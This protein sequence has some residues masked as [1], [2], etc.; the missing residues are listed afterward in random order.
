MKAQVEIMG[1]VIVVILLVVGA[2]LYLKFG[3]LQG[4]NIEESNTLQ[5]NYASN[6]LNSI[7]NVR[8]CDKKTGFDEGMIM[9]F[10]GQNLCDRTACSYLS[11]EIKD[12]MGSLGLKDEQKYS[13]WVDNKGKKVYVFQDKC[14]T[15]VKVD[16]KVV[17]S[18]KL[19]YQV[20][21][22]LC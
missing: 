12:I 3:I 13:I 10:K 6:L 20:N 14:E 8:A 15:G 4:E 1:L 21:L 16:T 2:L 17:G 11:T 19:A 18:D 9:C 7:L 5:I 22:K